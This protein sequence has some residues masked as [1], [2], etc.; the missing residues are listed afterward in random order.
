M[1][2]YYENQRYEDKPHT[3]S[4]KISILIPNRSFSASKNYMSLTVTSVL[5]EASEV[6]H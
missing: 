4:K 1:T 6:L 5:V 3:S 2:V